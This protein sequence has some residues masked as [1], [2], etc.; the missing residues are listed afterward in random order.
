M[1]AHAPK[2]NQI[3]TNFRPGLRQRRSSFNAAVAAVEAA[4]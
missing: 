1:G 2:K 3:D 4:R